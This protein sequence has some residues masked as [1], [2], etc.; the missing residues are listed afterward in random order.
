MRR[1][2]VALVAAA[3]VAAAEVAALVARA[4]ITAFVA[5]ATL[6][7]V[8]AELPVGAISA[9]LLPV[10]I[11]ALAFEARALVTGLLTRLRSRCAFGGRR[12]N[13]GIRRRTLARFAEF[14]VAA[15]AAMTLAAIRTLGGFAGS[16]LST[17][18]RAAVMALAVAICG[19]R[20]S[21]R[22]PGRQTSI[23]T[24]SAGASGTASAASPG[25][26]RLR[27]QTQARPGQLR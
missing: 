21:E 10:A 17:L 4:T 25:R 16:G 22:P 27:P 9:A 26:L 3:L 19:R 23:S 13:R 14:V 18:A 1:T 8:A 5:V 12:G 11:A 20:S 24:G 6:V 15:A 7:A 2:A